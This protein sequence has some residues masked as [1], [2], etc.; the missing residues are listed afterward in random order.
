[1]GGYPTKFLFFMKLKKHGFLFLFEFMNRSA[2]FG[3][4]FPEDYQ[5]II[6]NAFSRF[7]G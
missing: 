2:Y 7:R 3:A 1:M 5:E 4:Y 6:I